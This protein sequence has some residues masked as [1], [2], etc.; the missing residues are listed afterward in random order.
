MKK[1]MR[2]S[3]AHLSQELSVK[4]LH[5][6]VLMGSTQLLSTVDLIQGGRPLP[7]QHGIQHLDSRRG[8]GLSAAADASAGTRHHLEEMELFLAAY[9]LVQQHP[10]VPHPVCHSDVQDAISDGHLQLPQAFHGTHFRELQLVR[11][12]A[13]EKLAGC[14]QGSL[15]DSA[16]RAENIACTGGDPQR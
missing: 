12:L 1:L 15:H 10:C 13:R 5:V 6:R 14:S 11:R 9:D 2:P 3:A 7:Q 8:I 4:G 16:G